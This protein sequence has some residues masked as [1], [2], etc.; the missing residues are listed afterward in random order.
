MNKV[1]NVVVL[2][3][4]LSPE[5]EVSKESSNAIYS[6]LKKNG[7]NVKVIDPGYGIG[8]PE[9][10]EQFFSPDFKPLNPEEFYKVF[11]L[12]EFSEADIVFNGLHGGWGEDGHVQALLDVKNIKYTGSGVLASSLGMD[13]NKSKVLFEK[14]G[15]PT[16]PWINLEKYYELEKVF[17]EIENS[18]KYPCIIKPN[19]AGSTVGLTL[20]EKKE[21][22]KEA[23]EKAFLYSESVLIEKYIK[24]R[25]VTVGIVGDKIL[26]V[27]EIKPKKA[28][29]DYE[30]KYTDGMSEYEVPAK[31]DLDVFRQLQESA[32]KA[33]NAVGCRGY[34]RVDFL[35]NEKNEYYCLEINTL[36]GMT[37]HSLVPKM[38][39]YIGIDFSNLCELIIDEALK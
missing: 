9:S 10:V 5:R 29:Y 11:D 15:V 2:S 16:A 38:A 24:G 6:T 3:G 21:E 22:V 14:V 12:K 33:Y 37:S 35:L 4:G 32:I 26:P 20:C 31:I 39:A 34:G 8:Q 13:K 19:A 23:I 18:I 27:L 30:C 25:E 17:L 1:L 28:I 36:P 7:H